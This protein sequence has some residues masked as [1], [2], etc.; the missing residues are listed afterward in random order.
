MEELTHTKC[1]VIQYD[2]VGMNA[3]LMGQYI[4]FVADR[5]LVALGYDKLYCV[6]N[7][8]DWMELISLQV[9]RC[10]CLSAQARPLS[11][12]GSTWVAQHSMVY[13]RAHP[14]ILR[15]ILYCTSHVI[16]QAHLHPLSV[17][18]IEVEREDR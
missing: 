16:Q 5:L 6:P 8:F 3:A 18:V 13:I 10:T 1:N 12:P 7:P 2:Q 9:R 17:Y 15:C 11:F 4:E 14:C